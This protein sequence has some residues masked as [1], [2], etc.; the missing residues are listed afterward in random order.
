MS[1][2]GALQIG[3]SAI[4]ASQ[5]AI[6]VAGNNMANAAT[7]GP[8]RRSLM[9]P[10]FVLDSA[11]QEKSKRL[12]LRTR[13]VASSFKMRPHLDAEAWSARSRS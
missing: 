12:L 3:Q 2:N 5:T 11:T 4:V 6:Q 7:E 8:Y 10:M 9:P 1:L 13:L